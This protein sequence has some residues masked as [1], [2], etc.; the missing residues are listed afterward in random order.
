MKE[1]GKKID[2]HLHSF[3]SDGEESPEEVIQH[4]REAGQEVIAI[5][6]HNKFTF[7]ERKMVNGVLVIPGCE[8]STAYKAS[9][10]EAGNENNENNENKEEGVVEEDAN[11]NKEEGAVE[12][13]AKEV[14]VV[15]LF[16]NGIN[17]ADFADLLDPIREGKLAYDAALL[18]DLATRGIYITMEELHAG[19]DKEKMSGRHRIA[20]VMVKKGYEASVEDAFDHQIGNFSPYYI[21]SC[22]YIRYASMAAIVKRIRDCGGIPCLAHPFGYKMKADEIEQ[23]IRDFKE[24]AGEV[25]A[26]EVYYE[27]YLDDKDKMDF[28]IWMQIKYSLLP[29]ASSDRHRKDQPFASAGNTVLYENMVKLLNC[30]GNESI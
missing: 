29:S 3:C 15:G 11:E 21:P 22:R 10:E 5:T 19:A 2:L 20:E 26:M 14:H 28:L 12:E 4:A 27:L 25:A 24:A 30:S 16:P 8:F 1:Q 6:D 23:L 7:T 17:P 9:S 13:D 18:A